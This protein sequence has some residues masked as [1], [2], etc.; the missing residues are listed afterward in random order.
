MAHIYHRNFT[1]FVWSIWDREP[2]LDEEIEREAYALIRAQCLRMQVTLYAL[3]GVADHVHLLV[4]LPRTVSGRLHGS[5]QRSLFQS[6]ERHPRVAD[7][8]LQVA[9]QLQ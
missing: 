7:L 3:G 9:G 2:L 4:S 8:G 6:A 1:H 5:R